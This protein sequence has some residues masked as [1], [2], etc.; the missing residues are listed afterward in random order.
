MPAIRDRRKP[1]GRLSE[2]PEPR[3]DLL[4]RRWFELTAKFGWQGLH[5]FAHRERM[6]DQTI[7]VECVGR[8]VVHLQRGALGGQGQGSPDT[9]SGLG[10]GHGPI[11]VQEADSAVLTHLTDEVDLALGEGQ[12]IQIRLEVGGETAGQAPMHFL[13]RATFQGTG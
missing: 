4:G 8:I 1:L 6:A 13:G 9:L 10:C 5:L 7:S 12:G 11:D 2:T 3:P